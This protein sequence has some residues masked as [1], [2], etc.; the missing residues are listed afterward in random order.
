MGLTF[1]Y[2]QWAL[3]IFMVNAPYWIVTGARKIWWPPLRS[4]LDNGFEIRS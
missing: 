2:N 1:I 3:V 4:N